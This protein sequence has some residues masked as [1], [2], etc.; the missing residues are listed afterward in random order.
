MAFRKR[1]KREATTSSIFPCFSRT[2][3]VLAELPPSFN[4]PVA[5]IHRG[6]SKF[7]RIKTC[8]LT[9]TG[10]GFFLFSLSVSLFSF[11]FFF[12]ICPIDYLLTWRVSIGQT[13]F[14]VPRGCGAGF[15]VNGDEGG[16]SEEIN[17]NDRSNLES[18]WVFFW[19]IEWFISI[20]RCL[21]G[22]QSLMMRL[23]MAA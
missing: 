3:R 19:T 16:S 14:R 12:S 20:L 21:S 17:V 9:V 2:T 7:W 23:G 6:R 10:R 18:F 1:T 15:H 8:K 22:I 13:R 5:F 11:F 4:Y